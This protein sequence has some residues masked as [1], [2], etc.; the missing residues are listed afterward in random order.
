MSRG[1]CTCTWSTGSITHQRR[2]AAHG[3]TAARSWCEPASRSRVS[4]RWRSAAGN[5]RGPRTVPGTRAPRTGA[6]ASTATLDG[7]RPARVRR[8]SGSTRASP[9]LLRTAR[10]R[11]G[12]ACR[13]VRRPGGDGWKPGRS[14][15]H[16]CR[17]ARRCGLAIVIVTCSSAARTCPPPG[18]GRSRCRPAASRARRRPSRR[19]P[20][21]CSVRLACALSNPITDGTS[22]SCSESGL[23]QTFVGSV[24]AMKFTISMWFGSV[25]A[26]GRQA[27]C[28]VVSTATAT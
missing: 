18:S 9:S 27:G 16:H 17:A 11:G 10:G 4:T 8:T 6:R 3:A 7:D 15:R 13:R 19:S 5:R 23:V 25:N 12:S 26:L 22:T 14:G 2:D 21:S 20:A 24:P 28:C 1:A